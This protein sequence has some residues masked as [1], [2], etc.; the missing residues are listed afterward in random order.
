MRKKSRL[1]WNLLF[2]C[3]RTLWGQRRS[4][5]AAPR[6][7]QR[8]GRV[9]LQTRPA[10]HSQT[11]PTL[12][13]MLKGKIFSWYGKIPFIFIYSKIL[14]QLFFSLQTTAQGTSGTSKH[15]IYWLDMKDPPTS[16]MDALVQLDFMAFTCIKKN[17]SPLPSFCLWQHREVCVYR[18]KGRETES[19]STK[20]VILIWCFSIGGGECQIPDS[21]TPAKVGS[22]VWSR[23][24]EV[25]VSA[26][27]T[28]L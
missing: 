9:E 6:K 27:K 21:C 3:V 24:L 16:H 25:F 28:K 7:K 18:K 26:F 2:G 23:S 11:F 13:R 10:L 5:G 14:F 12:K 17:V 15:H 22:I 20:N 19:E 4:T 8:G 1:F